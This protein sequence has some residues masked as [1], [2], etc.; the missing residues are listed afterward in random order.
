MMPQRVS[1]A[2]CDRCQSVLEA[3]DLRCPVCGL[4]TPMPPVEVERARARVVRCGTCQ[5]VVAYDVERGSPLCAFCG[6]VTA[7]EVPP[8]PVE[9]AEHILP[10]LVDE[11]EARDALRR[12]LRGL[13]FFRPSALSREAVIDALQPLHWAAWRVI[14]DATVSWAADSDLGARDAEW[15]PHAGQKRL[16]FGE[17]LVP[18]TR[19]LTT[20]E[21]SALTPDYRL[22]TRQASRVDDAIVEQFELPRSAARALIL[23]SI[24]LD[25]RERIA[26]ESVPGYRLRNFHVSVVLEGLA[27]ERLAL[28]AWVL[29]YRWRGKTYRAVVHGQNATRVFGTAPWSY[30][31]IAL[32][33]VGAV[34]AVAAVYALGVW[35]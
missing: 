22:A 29:A 31:K 26:N 27:T 8:D 6:S 4:A 14:A 23:R 17:M 11:T 32:V 15:A 9:Q 7:I 28:P 12:W 3:E 16:S 5:A 2:A 10:F 20:T 35:G 19:G 18:A 33:A 24:E 1:E 30:V 13:G 25:A 34:A 21:T